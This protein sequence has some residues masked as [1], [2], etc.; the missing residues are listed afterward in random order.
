MLKLSWNQPKKGLKWTKLIRF[1]Q[2][3]AKIV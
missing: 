1:E 3:I 2:T